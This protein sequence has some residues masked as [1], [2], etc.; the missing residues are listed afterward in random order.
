M[1]FKQCFASSLFLQGFQK[2]HGL[3]QPFNENKSFQKVNNN[4]LFSIVKTVKMCV[5]T[6]LSM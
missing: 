4:F 6:R 3:S 1:N 5:L 2:V